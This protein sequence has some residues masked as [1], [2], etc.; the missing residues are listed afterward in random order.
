MVDT[1]E[2]LGRSDEIAELRRKLYTDYGILVVTADTNF[3]D[4]TG[5]TGKAL[6]MVESIRSTEDGRI[7]AHTVIRGKKDT[8]KLKW[9][10]GGPPPLGFQLKPVVD[11]SA[12]ARRMHSILEPIPGHIAAVRLAFAYAAETGFG[13]LRMAKWWNACPDIPDNLKPM[14]PY[15]M[16]Y[17]VSNRIY[18][19]TLV[20]SAQ[21][22]RSRER[23]ARD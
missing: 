11:E 17:M 15:T 19:G 1:L 18:I 16:G 23:H 13:A 10:P 9:W 12:T 6:G 7:K 2:R 5:P 21:H 3:A 22:D 14:S 8:A 20:C 4:P